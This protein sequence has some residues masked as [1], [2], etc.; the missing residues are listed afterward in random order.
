MT[1]KQTSPQDAAQGGHNRFQKTRSFLSISDYATLNYQ[2]WNNI[3]EALTICSN[4]AGL[5]ETNQQQAVIIRELRATLNDIAK[6][7]LNN[8]N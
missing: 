5:I 7:S 4:F 1:D 3:R 6:L 2:D 8:Q